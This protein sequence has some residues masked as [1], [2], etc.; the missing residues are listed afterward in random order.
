MLGGPRRWAGQGRPLRVLWTGV[1]RAIKALPLLLR[2]LARLP[3]EFP[4]EV[5]VLGDGPHRRRLQRMAQRLGVDE[6][7]TWLGWRPHHEALAE[8]SWADAFVFTSLRDNFPTVI[9]EALSAGLPVIVL[10]HQGVKDIV[11]PEAGIKIP[12][13][14]PAQV[15]ADLARALQELGADPERWE[16]MSRAAA[17]R[18]QDFLWPRLGE[19][20]AEIYRQVLAG[21][22]VSES[23]FALNGPSRTH[24]AVTVPTWGNTG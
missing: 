17:A 9:L 10:D 8:Y 6:K 1:L 4:V 18:A 12:V 14:T 24:T 22:P 2:A 7:I 15:V 23:T 16:R 19:Q 13:E 5:R 3:A 20:M 11:T 21:Q